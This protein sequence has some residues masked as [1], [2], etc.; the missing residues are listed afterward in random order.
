VASSLDAPS[1]RGRR[2]V[3]SVPLRADQ[4]LNVFGYAG[5]LRADVSVRGAALMATPLALAAGWRA[6]RTVAKRIGATLMHGH[7]VVPGGAM[8]AAASRELPLV[9]SLHGSDV[10]LAER[11]GGDRARCAMDVRAGRPP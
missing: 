8:A 11:H 1:A 10:Y 7:W 2:H 3:P 9:I 5:A 6:A 4:S